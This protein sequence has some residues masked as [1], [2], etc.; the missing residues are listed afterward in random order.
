MNS[1]GA[2]LNIQGNTDTRFILDD[3]DVIAFAKKHGLSEQQVLDNDTSFLEYMRERDKPSAVINKK[4][5][6]IYNGCYVTVSYQ[7]QEDDAK[8]LRDGMSRFY[9]TDGD[10]KPNM[11]N[12]FELI[13]A[14]KD[15]AQVLQT[16]NRIISNYSY[17]V[18]TQGVWLCGNFGI[19]KTYIMGA[20]AYAL[21]KKGA[22]VMFVSSVKLLSNL[23]ETFDSNDKNR[24]TT[25]LTMAKKAEVL[26]LDDLGAESTGTWGYKTVLYDILNERMNN[27]RLTFFTSNLSQQEFSE[28]VMNALKSR[29]DAGRF[30]ERIRKL[31][32]QIQMNGRNRRHDR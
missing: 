22:S 20:V 18:S 28:Q 24:Y 19:G 4:P 1:I 17:K 6:L 7:V 23:K 11:Y 26:I 14:D 32:Y 31:S 3:K 30:Y 9:Y 5:I 15:N 8:R 10:T 21:Y 13:E 27:N 12:E 29:A 25:L 16:L 2:F